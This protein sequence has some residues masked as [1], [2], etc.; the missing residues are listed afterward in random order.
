M[1]PKIA[2]IVFVVGILGLFVL[3]REKKSR[4]STA[5]WIPVMWILIVASRPL[6]TWLQFPPPDGSD[7]YLDGSPFD[8]FVFICLELSGL[9]VLILR[10]RQ[11]GS[12]LRRNGPIVLFF[13]FCGLS[14][15][16][17]DY[18]FVAFKRWIKG[19]GDV[20]MI[21]IVLTDLEPKEAIKRLF[22]RVSFLLIPF[23]VMLIKYF[24]E[25]GR[26]YK[27]FEWTPVYTGVTTGKNL[28]GMTCLMCGLASLWRFLQA[29]RGDEGTRKKGTLVAHSALLLMVFW[30][31]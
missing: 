13:F 20:V 18:P 23:S 14:I 27:R 19:L 5:L 9:V 12:L 3:D 6:S 28:L 25:M 21:L 22:A 2:A 16:W 31:F 26:A 8:R 4:T 24:P 10:S 30:L 15:F 1:P 17:A 7:P 29:V 11:V